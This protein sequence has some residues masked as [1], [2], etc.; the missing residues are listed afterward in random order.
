LK[1]GAVELAPAAVGIILGVTK[2]LSLASKAF[3]SYGR[4]MWHELVPSICKGNTISAIRK[5]IV[6]RAIVERAIVERDSR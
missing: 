3:F 5:A 1:A 2:K 4:L 6:E